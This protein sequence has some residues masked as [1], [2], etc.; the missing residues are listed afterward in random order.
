VTGTAPQPGYTGFIAELS[1]AQDTFCVQVL[2]LAGDVTDPA[3]V[4]MPP[5]MLDLTSPD[6][7]AAA[8]CAVRV[9]ASRGWEM[10]GA[11]EPDDL[12]CLHWAPV[13]HVPGQACAGPSGD[14]PDRDLP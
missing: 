5:V 14:S 3:Q 8:I 13:T 6:G 11:R 10:T 7:I 12:M 4:I 2:S 9:L 1:Q